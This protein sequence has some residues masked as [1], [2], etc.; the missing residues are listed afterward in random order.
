MKD[1]TRAS[2]AGTEMV[3]VHNMIIRGLNSIYQ[4]APNVKEEKDISDF[5]TY[6]FGWATL[7][8]MH[9][10]NEEA[11]AFPLLEKDI[12]I[13]G[14]MEKNVDQHKLF[15]P[16]LKAYDAY[17]PAVREGKEKF[18]GA[19]VRTII[20][21]FGHVLTQHLTEEIGTLLELEKFADKI[22][23]DTWNKKVQ[24]KAVEAGDPVSPFSTPSP[25][26]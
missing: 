11:V 3:L 23:W 12:G 19:K 14:Y 25:I 6:M 2:A 21:S 16:G 4:Q 20:D 24:E 18:D 10:D 7:V 5:L 9:H 8:H 13:E 1:E 26:L 15:G 22:D 17:I